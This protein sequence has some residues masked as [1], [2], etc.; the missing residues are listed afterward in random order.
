[1]KLEL[2]DL[3][4]D[5]GEKPHRT[6]KQISKIYDYTD[7][8]GNLLFQVV[9]YVPKTFKQRRPD[10]QGGWIWS[11]HDRNTKQLAVR[12]V[13]YRL[14]EVI[15]AIQDTQF[16][17][18]CEGEKD[19]ETLHTMGF[20]ATCNP[21]GAGK[22]REEY[23]DSL[24]GAH[25]VIIPDNDDPGRR[26]ALDIG[27]S[28]Q[29][30]A[31]SMRYLTL[32]GDGVK[33]A[34]NWVEKGGTGEQLETLIQALQEWTPEAAPVQE[35]RH[36]PEIDISLAHLR[37]LAQESLD[38]LLAANEPPVLFVR[39]GQIVRLIRDEHNT[40]KIDTMN[41]YSLRGRMERVANYVRTTPK[42]N[43]I[44][45]DPPMSIV[46]DIITLG[47]W[48]F[49]PLTA[50]TETPA[51]RLDGTM[52]ETPGYDPITELYYAPLP[53]LRM[54]QIPEEPT[55]QHVKE[56]LN[57]LKEIICNFP[58]D[59][60]ASQANTIA[61]IMTPVL[62]N[63][64]PGLVPMILFDKPQAGT[65]ASLLADVITAIANGRTGSMINPPKDDDEFRK[66]ITSLMMVGT[67]IITIDNIEKKL[68]SVSLS[69]ALTDTTWKDRILGKSET[70][71]FPNRTI[72][73]G[74]G[75]NIQLGG[76]LPRRCYRVRL[77][78]KEARPWQRTG[79]KH[80]HLIQWV[81][82][83]RG[84]IVS[85]IL[86]LAQ[87]WIQEGRPIPKTI[88]ILGGYESWVETIGSIL[89]FA[90]EDKF[91]STMEEVYEDTDEDTPQW[92]AFIATW[93]NH[94]GSRYITLSQ[95][96]DYL[97]NSKDLAEALPMEFA[98]DIESK[99]FTRN[100]G[101]AMAK[102]SDVRYPNDLMI[103]R[104]KTQQ[105]ALTWQ[106]I[107]SKED[108]NSLNSQNSLFDGNNNPAT[109]VG[110]INSLNSLPDLDV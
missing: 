72:W 104:G 80:P 85:A 86:I 39:A 98:G 55:E 26:H 65:G 53:N 77:N 35:E 50:I 59:D 71:S 56:S 62:R 2:K 88:P 29:G 92:S 107:E 101:R 102:R 106:V 13:L 61:A 105:R 36:L 21:M 74:T 97:K 11:L 87:A 110:Q 44:P 52:L 9:R 68:F 60:E 54:P 91:L 27:R 63:L 99:G 8:Q 94:I 3:F 46:R 58:F 79:F 16:V 42:D 18:I 41:E 66:L 33:D 5:K 75:N 89:E 31:A 17:V 19:V 83:E 48:P 6:Q 25:V 4:L 100:L 103:R 90:G 67:N 93:R 1:M 30:K 51:I 7:E 76:D 20:I 34:T 95:L 64:I 96:V 12:L 10:G 45:T 38:A 15:H 49:P 43:V 57:L 23:S 84:R 22:W 28:L 37:N 81:L 47:E 73:I 78:A 32:T 70:P 108:I 82:E 14:P 24:R 69:K 40:P 109:N